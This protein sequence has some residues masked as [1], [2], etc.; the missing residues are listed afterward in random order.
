[1]IG[2]WIGSGLCA[3]GLIIWGLT[4]LYYFQ[5]KC[6]NIISKVIP[7]VKSIPFKVHLCDNRKNYIRFFLANK[8]VYVDYDVSRVIRLDGIMDW[9][10]LVLTDDVRI[11]E[12]KLDVVQLSLDWD[13]LKEELKATDVKVDN[14]ND[15]AITK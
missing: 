14:I 7:N 8:K 4:W 1:M 2:F 3:T 11:T 13:T 6:W 10:K 12:D 15:G 9:G 5:K